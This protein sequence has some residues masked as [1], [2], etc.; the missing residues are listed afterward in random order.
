LEQII[1]ARIL[2]SVTVNP[3]G[4]SPQP[5]AIARMLPRAWCV[6]INTAFPSGHYY[7]G[8]FNSRKEAADSRSGYVEKLCR[9]AAR[10]IVAL[11]KQAPPDDAKWLAAN[12]RSAT[13]TDCGTAPQKWF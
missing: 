2:S 4:K 11:V 5:K 8:P 9:E 13:I 7:F 6:E 1:M 10:G 3:Q 12:P